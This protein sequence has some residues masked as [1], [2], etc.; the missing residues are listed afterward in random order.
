MPVSKAARRSLSDWGCALFGRATE[1][2][3]LPPSK[4]G[5]GVDVLSLLLVGFAEDVPFSVL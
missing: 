3:E 1:M 4:D 2:M 5:A